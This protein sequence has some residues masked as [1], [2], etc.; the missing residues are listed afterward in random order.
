[1]VLALMGLD[2]TIMQTIHARTSFLPHEVSYAKKYADVM[3]QVTGR[4]QLEYGKLQEL[5]PA[6]LTWTAMGV[7]RPTENETLRKLG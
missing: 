7:E 3:G 2:D 6:K 5:V 1:M 4:R